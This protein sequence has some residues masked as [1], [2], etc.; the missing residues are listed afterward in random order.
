[1]ARF[2]ISQ[3]VTVDKNGFPWATFLANT[4]AC[5][6]L[7]LAIALVA[8]EALSPPYKLLLMTGFCGGFSTFSTFSAEALSLWL[9]GNTWLAVTYVISSLLVGIAVLGLAMRFF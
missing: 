1:M 4:L 3:W 8:K 5:F 9:N 6:V 2:A 7:G